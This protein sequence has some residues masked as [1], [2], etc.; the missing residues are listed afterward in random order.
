MAENGNSAILIALA[1]G[2]GSL[3]IIL[4]ATRLWA[5]KSKLATT[6]RLFSYHGRAYQ[7]IF[8]SIEALN[9]KSTLADLHSRSGNRPGQLG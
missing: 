4:C 7:S 5:R 2:L 8:Q 1:W 6:V 3:V 9:M